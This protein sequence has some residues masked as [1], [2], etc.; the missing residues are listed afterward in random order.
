MFKIFQFFSLFNIFLDPY[1]RPN[2]TS[3]VI[4][5][6]GTINITWTQTGC[7]N[8]FPSSTMVYLLSPVSGNWSLVTTTAASFHVIDSMIFLPSSTYQFRVNTRYVLNNEVIISDDSNI[9]NFTFPGLSF[10]IFASKIVC[11][12][13]MCIFPIQLRLFLLGFTS[14]ILHFVQRFRLHLV[15]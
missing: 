4:V 8:D 3:V 11:K 10:D 6:N 2:V 7:S 15:I 5:S 9:Y 12:F 1:T 14:R 13:T